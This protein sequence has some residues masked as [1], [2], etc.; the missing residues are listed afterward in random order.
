M[1]RSHLSAFLPTMSVANWHIERCAV[2]YTAHGKPYLD[3]TETPGLFVAVG[4]N[5]HS[6]KWAP[7]LGQ[8]ASDLVCGDPWDP[9]VPRSEFRAVY[10]GYD[11]PWLIR[12][13]WSDR[14]SAIES[15]GGRSPMRTGVLAPL[16]TPF[17][18]DGSVATDLYVRHAHALL[19]DGCVGLVP[20]GTTGEGPS[21]GLS[22]R[23]D[24]VDALVDGG[25]DPAHLLIGTGTTS[26]TD[27]AV[28][29]V[30]A[31]RAG[32]SGVLVLPPFYFRAATDDGLATYVSNLCSVT[33]IDIYLYHIPQVAGVG[34]PPPLARRL[35]D[36]HQRVVG[37]KDSTGDWE[38]TA[39]LLEAENMI[40]YPGSELPLLQALPL[41]AR[42]CISATANINASAIAA[43]IATW[44]AGDHERAGELHATVTRVRLAV[45]ALSA[46]PAQKALLAATTGDDRWRNL[47]APLEPLARSVTDQL[48]DDLIELGWKG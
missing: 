12:D 41:G 8:L 47:R 23:R 19:A 15:G 26:L 28:L 36:A 6:A 31:Q 42:G 48:H 21:V 14:V 32:A 27:T 20:F 35:T 16:L 45:Q 33:D 22:E 34:F 17:N 43:V 39:A 40:V 2:T 24:A 1:I 38:N 37:I 44:E 10:E 4:G 18:G 13:L 11:G 46:I 5:G 30:H 3:E 29:T 9:A 7:I 25:I